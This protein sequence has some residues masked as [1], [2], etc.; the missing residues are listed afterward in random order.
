MILWGLRDDF[1]RGLPRVS[2]NVKQIYPKICIM[3]LRTFEG[4]TVSPRSETVLTR[5]TFALE[6]GHKDADTITATSRCERVSWTEKFADQPVYTSR[7]AAPASRVPRTSGRRFPAMKKTVARDIASSEQANF[8]T[9]MTEDRTGE[10]RECWDTCSWA[11]QLW[12]R[13]R[14][15]GPQ[16]EKSWRSLTVLSRDLSVLGFSFSNLEAGLASGQ[17]NRNLMGMRWVIWC[18]CNIQYELNVAASRMQ[19]T[20]SIRYASSYS[21]RVGCQQLT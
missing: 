4:S 2:I 8:A 15:I 21:V 20:H 16:T 9:G 17:R 12:Q 11:R 6:K 19:H 18:D 10:I 3:L 13:R 7:E 1:S 5:L 14:E